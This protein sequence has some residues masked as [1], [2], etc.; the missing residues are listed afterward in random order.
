MKNLLQVTILT[1]FSFQAFAQAPTNTFPN[2][3]KVGIGIL[4]PVAALQIESPANT[5]QLRL[6]PVHGGTSSS[7]LPSVL[8]FYATFDNYSPDQSQRRTA[9]IKSH[10]SGGAWGHETMSFHVGTGGTNDSA[11][12]PLERMR[13]D[14]AGNVGI[15]TVSPDS[16]LAVNGTIHGKEVKVDMNIWPDYVFEKGYRLPSLIELE[17]SIK[18]EGHLPGIPSAAEVRLNGLD[19]GE[20]NAKLLL[21]I[22]ELT[23][24]IIEIKKENENDLLRLTKEIESLKAKMK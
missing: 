19:L 24:Y 23:L 20:M 22:E 9:S 5:I 6:S 21:K 3:G 2:T 10:F 17:A 15:G 16:K 18:E 12:E 7:S 14:G 4:A 11:V 13:I 8:D 1:I